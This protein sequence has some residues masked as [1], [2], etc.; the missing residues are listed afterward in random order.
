MRQREVDL[1]ERAALP[2][3]GEVGGRLVAIDLDRDVLDEGA[4]QFLA[5]ARRGRG[6]VPDDRVI[7]TKREKAVAFGLREDRQT[8]PFAGLELRLFC[9]F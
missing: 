9:L 8:F 5:V 1:I 3:Q 7:G 4:Q 6:R 2:A